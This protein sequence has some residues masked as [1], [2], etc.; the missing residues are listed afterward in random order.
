[1]NW[2]R[3]QGHWKQLKGKARQKWGQL[4]DDHAAM[5]DGQREE[6]AGKLQQRY[7]LSRDAAARPVTCRESP[8]QVPFPRDRLQRR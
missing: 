5:V 4:T 3:I 7:R 1:M 6:L 2:D 8:G